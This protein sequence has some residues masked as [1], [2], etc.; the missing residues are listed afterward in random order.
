MAKV[1]AVAFVLALAACGTAPRSSSVGSSVAFRPGAGIVESIQD[2]GVAA[3]QASASIQGAPPGISVYDAS[4]YNQS[5]YTYIAYARTD[6]PRLIVHMD[7][8]TRQSVSG[9]LAGLRIGERVQ[10]AADGRVTRP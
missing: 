4:T 5:S 7:D 1:V 10:I 8:G 3:P 6:V 2:Q 9:N